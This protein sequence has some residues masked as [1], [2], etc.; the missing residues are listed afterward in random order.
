MF[1]KIST[2]TQTQLS[3][4]ISDASWR[5]Q[6]TA[7]LTAKNAWTAGSNPWYEDLVARAHARNLQHLAKVGELTDAWARFHGILSTA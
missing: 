6:T 5:V 7:D 1:I 2:L 3:A 4:I